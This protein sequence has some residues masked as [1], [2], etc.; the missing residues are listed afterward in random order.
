MSQNSTVKVSSNSF[1][2]EH[3]HLDRN[4][5]NQLWSQDDESK[6]QHEA[7]RWSIWSDSAQIWGFGSLDTVASTT[8]LNSE[9]SLKKMNGNCWFRRRGKRTM[10]KQSKYYLTGTIHTGQDESTQIVHH[11][12]LQRARGGNGHFGVWRSSDTSDLFPAWVRTNESS[13]RQPVFDEGGKLKACKKWSLPW[14]QPHWIKPLRTPGQSSPTSSMFPGRRGFAAYL[15]P[16]LQRRVWVTFSRMQGEQ[17]SLVPPGLPCPQAEL[18]PTAVILPRRFLWSSWICPIAWFRSLKRVWV[19][20]PSCRCASGDPGPNVHSPVWIWHVPLEIN[21]DSCLLLGV[22]GP[23]RPGIETTHTACTCSS[24]PALETWSTHICSAV[25]LI[26]LKPKKQ[27][28]SLLKVTAPGHSRHY[29]QTSGAGFKPVAVCLPVGISALLLWQHYIL[30]S[31][32]IGKIRIH[33]Q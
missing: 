1:G 3:C 22:T 20:P 25:A 18:P 14:H 21:S 31:S 32:V 4:L 9:D 17:T 6:Q 23:L 16:G 7:E 13:S 11:V 15:H 29:S 19:C 33:L 28:L 12:G 8:E 26:R 27:Q 10:R 2:C 24:R 30:F 5:I